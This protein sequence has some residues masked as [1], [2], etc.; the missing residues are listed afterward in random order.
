[1]TDIN[2]QKLNKLTK[3]LLKLNSVEHKKPKEPTQK[4][5]NTKFKMFF[6]KNNNLRIK[7]VL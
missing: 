1:M 3:G 7:E 4:E 6:D 2:K 5:L